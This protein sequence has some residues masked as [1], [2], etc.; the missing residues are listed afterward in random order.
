ML[1]ISIYQLNNFYIYNID[2]LSHY[3]TSRFF[4]LRCVR[5]RLKDRSALCAPNIVNKRRT[6]KTFKHIIH[7]NSGPCGL[8][9]TLDP[10][11]FVIRQRP[12][13]QNPYVKRLLICLILFLY[14]TKDL[15]FMWKLL[16]KWPLDFLL[17]LDWLVII[18]FNITVKIVFR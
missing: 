4:D 3:T 17:Y 13:R 7:R 15:I 12:Q 14:E 11:H 16:W 9:A 5:D 1:Y 8:V 18:C 6:N 2:W 10:F